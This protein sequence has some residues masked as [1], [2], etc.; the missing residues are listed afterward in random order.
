ML[1]ILVRI[2]LKFLKTWA[3]ST[4][5]N[6]L[7]VLPHIQQ[8]NRCNK[9]FFKESNSK[10]AESTGDLIG[11]KTADKITKSSKT[12]QNASKELHS[13]TDANDIRIPRER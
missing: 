9:N 3:R 13:K 11:N 7:V 8:Y 4:V 6:I 5:K 1:K 2:E 12:S 10:T